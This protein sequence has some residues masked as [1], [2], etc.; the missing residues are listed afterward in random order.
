MTATATTET[1]AKVD[2]HEPTLKIENLHV[3]VAGREIIHGIDLEVSKGEVHAILGPNGSGKS[4]LA[5]ALMGRPGYDV[6][7]GTVRFKGE[8]L[9][10]MEPD[11]RARA[12]LFLC[13]QYPTSIPGVNMGNFLRLAVKARFGDQAVKNFRTELREKLRLLKMDLSYMGRYLNEGF[14]GGEKKKA[15][16]LQMAMLKPE[17]AIMDETDSG[18]D[19]D[20]FKV[21]ADGVNAMRGPD[22]GILVITHYNRMLEY[23]KPD[24][25]HILIGGK[26]AKEGGPEL[27]VEVDQ[28][29]YGP[30]IAELR[31]RGEEIELP[32]EGGATYAREE[33]VERHDDPFRAHGRTAI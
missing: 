23:I 30:I 14:S 29:G 3:T 27:A 25:V 9:L 24:Y 20:A 13:F 12:G 10:E 2:G 17:V 18:L 28:H 1:T 22:L 32:E 7:E 11:E 21:V 26:L 19:V 5:Y 16:I 8:D 4:T 15:E 6:T 33:P 31:A